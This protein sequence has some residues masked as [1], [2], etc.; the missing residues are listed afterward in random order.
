MR[1][2]GQIKAKSD[3][4]VSAYEVAIKNCKTME[5]LGSVNSV[6]TAGVVAMLA[7]IAMQLAE[8]NER[9]RQRSVETP[10]GE[11]LAAHLL[12]ELREEK[13]A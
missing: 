5:Q 9:T 10:D 12:K 11:S 7:E 1:T 2:A 8:M 4:I 3:E 13:L 6:L